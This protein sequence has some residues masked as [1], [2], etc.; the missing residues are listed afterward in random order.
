MN[1]NITIGTFTKMAADM[2]ER[3]DSGQDAHRTSLL[4]VIEDRNRAM[5]K[6]RGP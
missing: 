4:E 6:V 3:N 1:P 5:N 2:V